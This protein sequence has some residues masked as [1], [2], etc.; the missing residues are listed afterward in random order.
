LGTQGDSRRRFFH[1]PGINNWD[2]ALLKDTQITERVNLQFRGEFF[3]LFNHAQFL[4]PSGITGFSGGAPTSSSFGFVPG[5]L[6]GRIGQ[7]SLKLYF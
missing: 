4:T 3:N 2:F 6:P 7:L 5:T 1:G